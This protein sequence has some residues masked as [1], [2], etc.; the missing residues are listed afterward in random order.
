MICSKCGAEGKDMKELFPNGLCY[1][2]K[3]TTFAWT[4]YG[5]GKIVRDKG[6]DL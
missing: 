2:C 6:I 1:E 5:N 3:K 4:Q